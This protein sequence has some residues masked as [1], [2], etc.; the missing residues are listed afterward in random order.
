MSYRCI[1]AISISDEKDV[2]ILT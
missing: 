1:D 2:Y